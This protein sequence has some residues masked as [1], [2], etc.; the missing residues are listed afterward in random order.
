M[1]LQGVRNVKV[2]WY[3]INILQE[4]C[5]DGEYLMLQLFPESEVK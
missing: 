5:L 2:K 4:L 3:T 1:V